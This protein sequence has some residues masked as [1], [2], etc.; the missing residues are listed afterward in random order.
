MAVV[1][2]LGGSF[3]P[4]HRG[5]LALARTTL[6]LGLVQTV[7]LVPAA[8]PPHKE[9]PRDA[10]APTRLRMA[11]LLAAEDPRLSVDG[12]EL[13]RS[14]PSYTIETIRELMAGRHE[15]RYRLI[16]GSDMARIF[17]SWREFREILRL[18]P[19]LVAGRS[20]I[21]FSGL[22]VPP[23]PGLSPEESAILAAGR[24]PMA[25]VDISSTAVRH[26]LQK[27]AD[28]EELL[29]WLTRPVFDFIRANGL[30]AARTIVD[31]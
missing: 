28:D 13:S 1:G 3:N 17:A 9:I 2:I 23:Y 31:L 6:D 14:G 18:A 12:L 15:N 26:L 5:H 19:P 16:I 27:G 8:H 25:P 11:E 7:L 21:P 29:V 4:P 22:P 10:D 20:G 30:Y 24:F